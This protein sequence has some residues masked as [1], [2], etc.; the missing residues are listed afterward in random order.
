[1]N[2]EELPALNAALNALSAVLLLFGFFAIRS[3]R[4]EL[5]KK[6]MVTALMT[7]ALF[8]ASYLVYHALHGSTPF[9][10]EGSLRTVYFFILITHVVL[11]VVN[12]P[13]II[14]TVWRAYRG[15]F[16]RHKKIAKLTWFI[17]MYVSVTGVL[18]Y[19]MLYRWFP[20]K[21]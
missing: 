9:Q 5:H 13:L 8:L 6:I 19:M 14:T 18:V 4:R 1:M 7:S 16:D 3:G 20:G 15:A 11:A 21:A 2:T 10:R 12:L 17:W